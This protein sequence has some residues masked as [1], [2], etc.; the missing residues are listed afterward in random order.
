MDTKTTEPS[1]S[2]G[3][4][5]G[6]IAIARNAF[7]LVFNRIELAALEISE[8]RANLIKLCVIFALCIVAAWFAIAYW[9]ALV[10]VLAW[11]T[12]GWK[13]LLLLAGAFTAA[14]AGL[15]L[16]ARA[17]IAHGKLSMPATMDELRKDRDALL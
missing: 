8:V 13:V 1:V 17:M 9:S 7:G 14:G 15:F 2:P 5:A 6:V 3:L 12:M 4:V 10:V 16:Y 11:D